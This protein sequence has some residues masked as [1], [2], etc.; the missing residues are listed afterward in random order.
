[1]RERTIEHVSNYFYVAMRMHRKRS[2]R[3]NHIFIDDAKCPKSHPERLVVLVEGKAM[4]S[5]EPAIITISPL[6]AG[7]NSDHK[8][9]E[10]SQNVEAPVPHF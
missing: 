10:R 1:M 9:L 5:V 3:G 8:K 7:P 6:T 4:A 2:S